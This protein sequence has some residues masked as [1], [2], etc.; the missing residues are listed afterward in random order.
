M[1]E[2]VVHY[3][4]D[5]SVGKRLA[6]SFC[7]LTVLILSAAGAGWWGLRQQDD[8]QR[9][10]A[11]MERVRD[12]VQLMK[13]YAADV[14]G[15]QGLVAADAGAFGYAYATGADG[16]NRQ[17]ELKSKDAIYATYAA[18]H[19]GDMTPAERAKFAEL[20]PAWDDFFKWDATLMEWLRPDTQEARAKVMTSIN[21]GE[22][23]ESYGKVL[24]IT[25]ELEKS[26]DA[27]VASLRKEAADARTAS[28]LVLGGAL[29]VAL[30]LAVLMSILVTR[31]VV[32]PL[33]VVVDALHRLAQ[34]DLTARAEV[35]S[36]DEMGRLG[37]AL[38][39]TAAALRETVATI[40][41]HA[42]TLSAASEEL[43]VV[44]TQI[45]ASAEEADAQANV[46]TGAADQV[47]GNVNTLAAGS[48]EMG[49]SIQEIAR[50]AG[51]AART[52]AE[53]V[54]AARDTTA[55]VGKLGTSSAEIGDVVK[56]ITAIAEQTNLLALNATIEAARAGEMGKGF[57]VVAG[58]V[59]DLAQETA[60]ATEDIARRVQSIQADTDSAVGA[61][62]RISDVIGRI[63]DSQ[64]L[65]AAA[66]EEQTATASE[67]SRNVAE[68]ATG[69]REIA[70]NMAGVAV[71][72][73]TTATGVTQA[74]QASADLATMSNELHQLV[75]G[76]RV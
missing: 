72:V 42:G 71:A 16:Y 62:G 14:T 35:R 39:S 57:A 55:T 10:L 13:Y 19:T 48:E 69:S 63:S 54:T 53:A 66:V 4:R 41:G 32:R 31:S 44:S 45:A 7:V 18:A 27:R 3:F 11:A 46:V 52:A 60:K 6:L 30:V 37:E 33:S 9:R 75:A 64:N 1:L 47:S 5:V 21:G 68:A 12:D 26:V 43:S 28:L 59:K 8:A 38:N 67:M 36:R 65:I 40:A 22:A 58:E 50:N 74:Q 24:D 20:K 56:V 51:E 73:R 23:A 2:L 61:I 17:G 49:L 25:A 15:W 34:R 76:F 29:A 70:E